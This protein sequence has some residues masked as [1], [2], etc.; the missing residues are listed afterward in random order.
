[1]ESRQFPVTVHFNKRTREAYLREAYEKVCKI[2]RSL[3]S[4]HVLVFLTGQREV[5]RLCSLLRRTFPSTLD[6]HGGEKGERR[7]EGEKREEMRR[8]RGEGE[9]R[10]EGERGKQGRKRRSGE[11]VNLDK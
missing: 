7:E 11:D 8:G 3:P 2:H 5:L 10:E 1:M 4:G 6:N 9:E